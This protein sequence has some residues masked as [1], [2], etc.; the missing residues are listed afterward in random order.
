MIDPRPKLREAIK[1]RL[2]AGGLTDNLDRIVNLCADEAAK[3]MLD[4]RSL[5]QNAFLWTVPYKIIGDHLGY[6]PYEVHKLFTE[7]FLPKHCRNLNGTI[8]IIGST[9]TKLTKKDFSEYWEQ[10]QIFAMQ[11]WDLYI[12]DPSENLMVSKELEKE[13][14]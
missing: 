9:T 4:K 14:G 6:Y 8:D 7:M 2:I 12:P 3:I 13:T 10:I 11:E 1:A 5:K